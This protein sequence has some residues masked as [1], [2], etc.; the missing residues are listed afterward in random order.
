MTA[1][2][3]ERTCEEAMKR[4]S[5]AVDQIVAIPAGERTFANTMLALETATDHVA[6]AGGQY[7]FMAYVAEEEGLRETAREWEQRLDQYGIELAFREDL[8]GAVKE[9]SNTDEVAK[10]TGQPRRLVERALRD[11]RRIGFELAREERD[12]VRAL[13]NRL[14]ELSTEFQKAIDTW[15]DGI[16]ADREELIGLPEAF[17]SGLTKVESAGQQKYRVSLDYPELHPFMSNAERGDLRRELYLKDMAKGGPG[18]VAR[19]EEAIQVRH[20]IADL[21]GYR[22]WAAY[23]MEERMAKEP[24]RAMEFLV[25]LEGRVRLKAQGD[26]GA[27]KAARAAQDGGDSIDIWDWRFYTN[28]LLKTDYAIDEFEVAKY[29]PLE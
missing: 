2:D 1:A 14:V 27:L 6:Q 10:L 18:N 23:V 24:R 26:M 5:A 21:L 4:C 20:Q 19:L 25:D 13:M 22:S 16:E 8:Y 12:L 11:Y 9:F 3:V 29:F 17:I 7:G 28:R 15:E